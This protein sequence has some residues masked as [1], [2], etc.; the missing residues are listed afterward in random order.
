MH[1]RRLALAAL[2][3]GGMLAVGIMAVMQ[4]KPVDPVRTM[5]T[6]P[7]SD[8]ARSDGLARCR[9]VTEADPDCAALWEAERR[10]FFGQGKLPTSERTSRAGSD[11]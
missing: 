2:L 10:R 11:E 6:P 7:P 4:E 1:T 3:A 5:P 8:S 9:T